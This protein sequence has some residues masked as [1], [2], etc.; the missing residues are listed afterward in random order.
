MSER[1]EITTELGLTIEEAERMAGPRGRYTAKDFR[2]CHPDKY[3]LCVRALAAGFPKDAIRRDLN[4]AWET[5]RAVEAE[6]H[7]TGIRDQKRILAELCYSVAGRGLEELLADDK[8]MGK[9]SVIEIGILID[10]LLVLNGEA[11]SIHE[12]RVTE[13]AVA[14]LAD[15]QAK[16]AARMGLEGGNVSALPAPAP[17]LADLAVGPVIEAEIVELGGPSGNEP[18]DQAA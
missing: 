8:R 2:R 13:P 6:E 18:P 7:A 14:K 3:D 1:R 5:V 4:I 11:G 10:K 17:R 9:L 12:V 15:A 16:L